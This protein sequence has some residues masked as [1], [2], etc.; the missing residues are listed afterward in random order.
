MRFVSCLGERCFLE[1]GIWNLKFGFGYGSAVL[2][3]EPPT[4]LPL[5]LRPPILQPPGPTTQAFSGIS[6]NDIFPSL[7]SG[8]NVRV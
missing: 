7:A 3:Q 1:S 2:C 4:H 5:R 8:L 6:L